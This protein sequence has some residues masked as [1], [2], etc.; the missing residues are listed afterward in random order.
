M[1]KHERAF[2]FLFSIWYFE[3]K[4][5]YCQ[6]YVTTYASQNIVGNLLSS[7]QGQT[8]MFIIKATREVSK[9]DKGIYF[10]NNDF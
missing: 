3:L 10:K 2:Q 1:K 9:D 5:S 6:D 8:F 4:Q 7:R